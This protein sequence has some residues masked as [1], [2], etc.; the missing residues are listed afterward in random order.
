M[1]T[2]SRASTA[3]CR[4]ASHNTNDPTR[5]RSVCAASHVVVT[6]ASNIGWAS[7]IGGTQWSMPVTPTKPPVSAVCARLTSWSNERRICGRKRLNSIALP[8]EEFQHVV[9]HDLLLRSSIEA[10][11]LLLEVERLRETFAVGPVGTEQDAFD[12]DEVG[13]DF[14]VF[15]AVGR[16]PHMAA[17]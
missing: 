2:A 13:E 15:L 1:D 7:A 5:S 8:P 10:G 3:G 16:D 9:V 6:I 12:T 17:Q 14:E 4:N 11:D